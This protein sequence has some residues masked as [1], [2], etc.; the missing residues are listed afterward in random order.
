MK[1]IFS[2]GL[3]LCACLFMF[4]CGEVEDH[5]DCSEICDMWETGPFANKGDC[6]SLCT[7]CFN[8][9]ES[10]GNIAVC[11][12]NY[13]EAII[14]ADGGDWDDYDLKNKGQCVKMF[15]AELEDGNVLP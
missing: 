7:T 10:N 12:C 5:Q 1:S 11:I 3:L 4:S 14:E 6:V 8:P 15:K 13:V 9:S 2:F